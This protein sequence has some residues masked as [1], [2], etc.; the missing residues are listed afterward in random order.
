MTPEPLPSAGEPNAMSTTQTPA[1][2][3]STISVVRRLRAHQRTP[4]PSAESSRFG[5]GYING[6]IIPRVR[7]TP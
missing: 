7:C 6:G 5:G 3:C 2:P 1:A 4:A